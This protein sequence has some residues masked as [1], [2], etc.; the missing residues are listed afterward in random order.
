M[1]ATSAER[2]VSLAPRDGKEHAHQPRR[3]PRAESRAAVL[4]Q[5]ALRHG[6]VPV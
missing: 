1:S 2:G 4:Q 3:R 6:R 5:D